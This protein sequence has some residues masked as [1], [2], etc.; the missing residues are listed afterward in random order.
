MDVMSGYGVAIVLAY[1]GAVVLFAVYFCK[2][3]G[4]GE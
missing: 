2:E 4:K 3:E 1:A